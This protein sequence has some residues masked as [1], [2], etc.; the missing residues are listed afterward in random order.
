ME[1]SKCYELRRKQV[2]PIDLL[3]AWEFFSNPYN[4]A[5]IT[6]KWM[7]FTIVGE[8]DELIYAGQIIKYRVNILPLFRVSW[9]T[10][11]AHMR[12]P[13]FFV[14]Q[15]QI[16]PYRFWYHQHL[17]RSHPEGTVVID[18]VSY[19]LPFGILGRI[20]HALLVKRL[21]NQIFDYRYNVL[22]QLYSNARKVI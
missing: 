5:L 21:L 14:D 11:I 3:Q 19:V 2:L 1:L 4:L 9:I 6:P 13:E 12:A 18:I 7:N 22:A 10:E 15:Q 16:G 20:V 17:L 8:P